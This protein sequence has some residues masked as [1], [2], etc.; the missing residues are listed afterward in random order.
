MSTNPSAFTAFV[1]STGGTFTGLVNTTGI[2]NTGTVTSTGNVD[3]TGAGSGLR[4]A[5]GA[6]AKQGTA[7]LAAGTVVVAN[8]SVTATSRIF[9]TLVTL[10]TVTV[11]SA[12]GVSARVAGTSFTILASVNTDTSTVAYEIVEPG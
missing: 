11:P 12:Y 5:E 10:G 3:V 1:P 6:N 2:A 7:I 8:T 4:V 9:V